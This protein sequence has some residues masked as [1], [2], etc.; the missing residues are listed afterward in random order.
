M[1]TIKEIR[2][3]LEESEIRT[4]EKQEEK[5]EL[6][7]DIQSIDWDLEYL[8]EEQVKLQNELFDN[9]PITLFVDFDRND[10]AGQFTRNGKWRVCNGYV[11][12]ESNDKFEELDEVKGVNIDFETLTNYPKIEI[13]IDDFS[14]ENTNATTTQYNINGFLFNLSYVENAIKIMGEN[15]IEEIAIYDTSNK[16]SKSGNLYIKSKN[17]QT[18]I[19]GIRN[20][21]V[22]HE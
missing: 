21:E 13:S 18:V 19:L 11:L 2:E 10:I 1:R 20:L 7:E 12:F 14:E 8:E 4:F 5:R 17:M 22:N 3:D 16:M 9:Y 6:E 15:N